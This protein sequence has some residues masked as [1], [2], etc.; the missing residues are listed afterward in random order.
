MSYHNQI[1]ML[2]KK[3]KLF[4][5]NLLPPPAIK[6]QLSSYRMSQECQH[7]DEIANSVFHFGFRQAES[8]TLKR[9]NRFPTYCPIFL[10]TLSMGNPNLI[11][12]LMV[13]VS[14]KM[15]WRIEVCSLKKWECSVTLAVILQKNLIFNNLNFK[16]MLFNFNPLGFLN[17]LST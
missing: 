1:K 11:R 9:R 6:N 8:G 14:R 13:R 17:S 12:L 2:I 4:L 15:A 10:L 5:R 7:R 16:S 3:N